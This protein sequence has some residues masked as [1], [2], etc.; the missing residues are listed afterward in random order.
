[1]SLRIDLRRFA[2]LSLCGM[3]AACSTAGTGVELHLTGISAA[4]DRLDV[5]ATFPTSTSTR[6]L[7][8]SPA[9]TLPLTI[10]AELP[11][12]LN[13]VSFTVTA[14]SGGQTVGSGMT[15]M[16]VDVTPHLIAHAEV[17][18]SAGPMDMGSTDATSAVDQIIPDLMPPALIDQ[19]LVD[20]PIADQ[21][22]SDLLAA[23][24]MAVVDAV[25][26]V[27]AAVSDMAAPTDL[28]TPS[29]LVPPPDL[30]SP[31]D[32]TYLPIAIRGVFP[33]GPS[34]SNMITV[35]R[36]SSTQP[37]D[38]MWLIVFASNGGSS[39]V[40]NDLTTSGWT[41]Q[42]N[43]PAD[44]CG[45]YQAWFYY[46]VAGSSEASTYTFTVD[47]AVQLSAELV[48]YDNVDPNTP[49]NNAQS[50]RIEMNPLMIPSLPTFAPNTQLVVMLAI[51]DGVG[52]WSAPAGFAQKVN[53][54][55]IEVFDE[56]DTTSGA[57][58]VE[59]FTT[60]SGSGHCGAYDFVALNHK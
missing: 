60:S 45:G 57:T 56:L 2:V 4:I 53:T 39:S 34:T 21:S 1:M 26:P 42:A 54:S 23:R 58:G 28:A 49:I 18:L 38:L 47:G 14:S 46:K 52:T 25:L 29:D 12:A 9:R 24:D 51:N 36:P 43:W 59:S 55:A 33:Q 16:P 5:T 6:T 37:G 19:G 31:P 50:D 30:V 13:S 7:Q 35:T 32:M 10:L 40:V 11:D 48:V 27:D 17:S 15:A 20:L 44:S 41:L 8:L 3:L 22:M